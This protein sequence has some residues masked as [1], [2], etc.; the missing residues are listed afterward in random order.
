MVLEAG[1]YLLGYGE[2]AP[3]SLFVYFGVYTIIAGVVAILVRLIYQV[4][5][6]RD[7]ER[8]TRVLRDCLDQLPR[9][10]LAARD[11]ALESYTAEDA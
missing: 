11:R 9:L 7:V 10:L 1:G 3:A 5:R 2:A 6:G 4:T 8:G